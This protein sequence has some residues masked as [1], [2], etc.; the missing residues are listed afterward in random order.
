MT[1]ENSPV[2]SPDAANA[3]GAGSSMSPSIRPL[4]STT[5]V[6]PKASEPTLAEPPKP[7]IQAF[8][9]A[10]GAKRH[11]DQ[12]KRSPN[13]TGTGAIHCKSFHCKL[14]DDALAFLDEQVNQWLDAH[15]QYEVKFVNTCVGEFAGKLG[16]E[17]HLVMQ[18]WV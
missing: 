14:S 9:Q 4:G 15:P 18:V 1:R 8:Q 5:P 7:K 16:K 6:S 10:L 3:S 2:R 17:P 13:L 11:E 12:W